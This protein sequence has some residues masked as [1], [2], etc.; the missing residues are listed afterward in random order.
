MFSCWFCLRRQGLC[1]FMPEA[2]FNCGCLCSFE[3]DFLI[4][5]DL[6]LALLPLQWESENNGNKTVCNIFCFSFTS[7]IVTDA[8]KIKLQIYFDQIVFIDISVL[9]WLTIHPVHSDQP[10]HS[11]DVK[12]FFLFASTESFHIFPLTSSYFCVSFKWLEFQVYKF[13]MN[14][15]CNFRWGYLTDQVFSIHRVNSTHFPISFSIPTS[16]LQ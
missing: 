14:P 11:T 1:L 4:R 5:F 9:F 8:S 6:S 2:M 16:S 3:R 7:R 13:L 12:L 15:N 10:S